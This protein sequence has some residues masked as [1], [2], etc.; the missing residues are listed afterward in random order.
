MS[1]IVLYHALFSTCSQ[2]VRFALAAKNLDYES[3]L[4]DLRK[5]EHLDDWYLKINPNGVVPALTHG[6][7]RRRLIGHLRISR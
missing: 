5:G 2:K 3:R 1:G 6:G 4:V 7:Q